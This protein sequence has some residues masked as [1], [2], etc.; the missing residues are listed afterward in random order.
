MC[1]STQ[2][3]SKEVH[4][5]W[6]RTASLLLAALLTT[7]CATAGTVGSGWPGQGLPL[8]ISEEALEQGTEAEA[9][10]TLAQVWAV[11]S[12]VH[13]VGARLSFTFWVEHGALTLTGYAASGRNGPLGHEVNP[14]AIQHTLE[15]I[16]E[17]FAQQHTGE[18]E[19][20]LVR[21]EAGWNVEYTS[22]RQAPRPTEAKALPVRRK[23][24][25]KD[26]VEAATEGIRRLLK[27]MEVSAGS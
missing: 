27:S 24:L 6:L 9:A 19:M 7:G 25:P 13:A 21:G 23:G 10:L 22:N 17:R 16:I 4:V 26:V 8:N 12:G 14:K 11:A 5:P 15:T 2:C 20:I 18:V 1:A 3:C